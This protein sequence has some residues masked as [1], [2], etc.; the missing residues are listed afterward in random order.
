MILDA[1]IIWEL[2][3][4][5]VGRTG[6]STDCNRRVNAAQLESPNDSGDHPSRVHSCGE[7]RAESSPLRSVRGQRAV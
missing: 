4:L 1:W 6:R 3:G 7:T 5:Q 2:R